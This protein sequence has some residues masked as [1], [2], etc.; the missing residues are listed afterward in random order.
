MKNG[1]FQELRQFLTKLPAGQIP[2]DKQTTLVQ[3]LQDCWDAFRGSGEEGMATYKLTRMEEPTW[4]PPHLTFIIERHGGTV[5]GST[6]AE[7]QIWDVDLDSKA[8]EC[9]VAGYRQLYSRDAILDVK[10]IADELAKLIICR[11][12]DERLQWSAAGRVRILTGGILSARSKQ[13]L[14]GRRKR[15]LKA[16]E[17]RLAPHGWT[18]RGSWWEQK[19]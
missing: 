3:L 18:R 11:N 15:L 19:E 10:P 12:Q 13:T 16:M 5:M 6:R 4:R 7:I 17:E 1:R 14:E 9:E 8:V 2:S